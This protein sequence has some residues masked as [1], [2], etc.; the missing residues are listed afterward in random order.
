MHSNPNIDNSYNPDVI[1]KTVVEHDEHGCKAALK[2]ALNQTRL[3]ALPSGNESV[4]I[5]SGIITAAIGSGG[6]ARV[7]KVWNEKL[8]VFRAVKILKPDKD[9]LKKRFETEAKITA[10]L[11]HPNIV[12]IY[13]VGEWEGLPYLEM[14]FI[15]GKSLEQLI[16]ER[17]KL[18]D[19]LCCA[20]MIQI[21]R[22]LYYAH[23]LEILLYGKTYHGVIHRDLKPANIMISEKGEVRLM[24]FGI[25]RPVEASL[26]TI[27]GGIVGTIQYLSPEQM[28]GEEV[29]CRTDI[30]SMGAVL[31]EML[32]GEKIFPQSSITELMR[33]RINNEFKKLSEYKF[34]I[35]PALTKISQKCLKAD[36]RE[37]YPDAN[38][39]IKDL[40]P[41]YKHFTHDSPEET[42]HKFQTAILSTGFMPVRSYRYRYLILSLLFFGIPV[43]FTITFFAVK[44]H[45]SDRADSTKSS[46]VIEENLK[47]VPLQPALN[48]KP[49]DVNKFKAENVPVEAPQR[50]SEAAEHTEIK[51]STRTTAEKADLTPLDKLKIKYKSSDLAV[52]GTKAFKKRSFEESILAF[53][54]LPSNH[55]SHTS[56]IIML[57]EAYLETGR[58]NKASSLLKKERPDD[59][60]FEYLC[61]LFFE[62]IKDN[63]KA[64]D[65][66]Q[67]ALIRPSRM[68]NRDEIRNDALYKIAILRSNQYHIDSTPDSRAMAVHAWEVVKKAYALNPE[69]ARVH[70]ATVELFKLNR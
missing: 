22:A 44:K 55:H 45:L 47:N 24:D 34:D 4:P 49:L 62:K 17:G 18:P 48:T 28:N 43:I 29:D 53:E 63:E 36:K 70:M 42:V 23:N 20:I 41:V 31:Y 26:H 60:Q 56:N 2:D 6:M 57:L 10:K 30:Y 1:D 9:D 16:V 68:R 12:E 32:T 46:L 19:E 15:S 11:H 33:R 5:G 54:S 38:A 21:S 37:R 67:R 39:L 7:Y 69:H 8:E 35:C 50:Y 40:V 51:E 13:N 52:V 3:V 61:G 66:Y 64:L 25:A 58:I 27:D 65:F 59:S 14:E